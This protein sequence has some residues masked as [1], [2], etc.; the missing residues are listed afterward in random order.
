MRSIDQLLPERD[1]AADRHAH[2]RRRVLAGIAE[3]TDGPRAVG[4]SRSVRVAAAGLAM[5]AA[6]AIVWAGSNVLSDSSRPGEVYALGDSVLS[7]STRA[8]GRQCLEFARF[9]DGHGALATWPADSPPMLLNYV[10][11]PGRGAIVVYQAH[12]RLVYC[13]I[14][15]A[16]KIGP[17]PREFT[18]DGSGSAGVGALDATRWLPGPISMESAG[19]TDVEGGYLHVAGRVSE[20]VA[21]VVLDDGAGHQRSARLAEGTFVVFSDGRTVPGAVL[22]SYD[23]SGA[24]IDRRPASQQPASR[25]YIDPAG[26]LVNPTSHHEFELA[27]RTNGGRCEPGEPWSRRNSTPAPR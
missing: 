10:E 12:L 2:L 20:R 25:C 15:P 6:G 11:Q 5:A 23:A 18:T 19:S 24:E 27:Y 22:I 3:P 4:R 14:G 16:V 21:R 13:S 1:L 7:P 8:T 9:D 17:E 26:K